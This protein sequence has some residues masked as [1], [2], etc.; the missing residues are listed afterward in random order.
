MRGFVAWFAEN[1]VA[2]NLLMIFILVAGAITGI[3]MKLEVF[4]EV[5]MDR[6]TISTEYIGASPAEVEEG[7]IRRIEEN[8]AGLAGIEDIALVLIGFVLLALEV[9]VIPGFGVAGVLGILCIASGL[10]M[11]LIPHIPKAPGG[12]PEMET[13]RPAKFLAAYLRV[14]LLDLAVSG[15]V[16]A[17]ALYFLGKILPKTPLY[18]SLVLEAAL[19][20]DEGYVAGGG[21]GYESYLGSTG[22]AMTP[23]RPAGTG[24]F[25]DDRLDVMSSGD[26]IPKGTAIVVTEVRGTSIVVEKQPPGDGEDAAV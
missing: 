7:I 3:T 16:G 22:V 12:L 1:H 2:A 4:P 18:R 21:V 11:G 6:I 19:S 10:L 26:L 5:S 14:A 25:G 24:V 17:L 13:L 23:L 9:F 20:R 15:G 8:V